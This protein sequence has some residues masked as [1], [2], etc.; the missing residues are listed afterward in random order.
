MAVARAGRLVVRRAP[1]RRPGDLSEEGDERVVRGDV[2]DGRAA[3]VWAVG[4]GAPHRADLGPRGDVAVVLVGDLAAL[5]EPRL[6]REAPARERVGLAGVGGML[7]LCDGADG[8][9]DARASHPYGSSVAICIRKL[10]TTRPAR[11]GRAKSPATTTG[12][13]GVRSPR[14]GTSL[15]SDIDT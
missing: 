7:Q 15:R 13:A 11:S 1:A 6:L 12:P 2:G 4:V 3:V 14:L 8:R 5:G 10:S 9:T